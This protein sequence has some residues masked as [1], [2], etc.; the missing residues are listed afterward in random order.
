MSPRIYFTYLK[1]N[2]RSISEKSVADFSNSKCGD[3]MKIKS[4][5]AIVI[6][7]VTVVAWINFIDFKFDELIPGKGEKFER[8]V[9][10]LC[11]S[12]IAAYIF[13]YLNVYLKDKREKRAVLPVIASYVMSIWNNNHSIIA[14]LKKDRR[15][16]QDYYPTKEEYKELLIKINPHHNTH[17][18]YNGKSWIYLFKTRREGTLAMIDNLYKTGRHLDDPVRSLLLQIQNSLYLKED[19]AFNS[20]EFSKETLADYYLVFWNYFELIKELRNYWIKN[21][22]SHW[23][24]TTPTFVKYGFNPDTGKWTFR[25]MPIQKIFYNFQWFLNRFRKT[26]K[27]ILKEPNSVKL[28]LDKFESEE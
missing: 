9:D 27:Y 26:P 4:L 18:F 19:Y 28:M 17:I 24:Q 10:N 13:Y 5:T 7:C 23:L 12:F 3:I 22:H 11:R 6:L 2:L 25:G 14:E 15:V 1:W 8:L 20:E 21:L 16:S